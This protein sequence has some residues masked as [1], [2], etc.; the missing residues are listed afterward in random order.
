MEHK[1]LV[2]RNP[3]TWDMR[4]ALAI[5]KWGG[6]T[7][8]LISIAGWLLMFHFACIALEGDA[9]WGEFLFAVPAI[10]YL[11][12]FRALGW[13]IKK[14]KSLFSQCI[15]VGI[16]I[17]AAFAW[18]SYDTHNNNYQIQTMGPRGCEHIYVTWWTH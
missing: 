5:L 12:S 17:A 16:I 2:F 18:Y 6:F 9:A 10:I 15:A 14:K 3:E 11:I 13:W 8:F 1:N 7:Y 4:S